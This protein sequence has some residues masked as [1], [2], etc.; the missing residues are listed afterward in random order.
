MCGIVK[1]IELLPLLSKKLKN[2]KSYDQY[3]IVNINNFGLPKERKFYGNG[4]DVVIYSLV[5]K[6][7][8]RNIVLKAFVK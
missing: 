5:Y 6:V 8:Q 7:Q 2:Y 4:V 1:F 3:I